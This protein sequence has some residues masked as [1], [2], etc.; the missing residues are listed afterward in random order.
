[1]DVKDWGRVITAMVTPYDEGLEINYTKA[2]ELAKKLENEGSTALVICG[3][4]GESPT[5]TDEEKLKLY[6]TIKDN[7]K[8]PVI[9]GVGTN[10]TSKTIENARKAV[11]FG[12]DGLLV[13]VPYYNKPNQDS[14]YEHFKAVAEAVDSKIMMY[15]VP[16]RTGVN[17]L[18]STVKKLS[19][20]D[21]IVSLKEA[22]GNIAQFTDMVKLTPDSFSV[23]TGDDVMTL[24]CLSVGGYGVVSVAAHIVGLKMKEMIDGFLNGD[25]E[26]AAKI[27]LELNDIFNKLFI[28]TNPIVVKAALNLLGMNVGELRLPLTTA[29]PAIQAEIQICLRKIGLMD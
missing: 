27:N 29:R 16:G 2:V 9:A 12:V 5:L 1:M 4:T 18:P 21:N 25:V 19:K 6:K 23:Y 11:Q 3:T 10:S 17:M 15:N 14:I 22:S 26:K 8:I 7:V 20:I 24:P 13:I 28:T